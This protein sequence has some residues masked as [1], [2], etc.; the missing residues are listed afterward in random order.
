MRARTTGFSRQRSR[1]QG[2]EMRTANGARHAPVADDVSLQC[3]RG[4]AQDDSSALPLDTRLK[5]TLLE[6]A[7]LKVVLGTSQR[8]VM[9]VQR[10]VMAVREQVE[11]WKV[12]FRPQVYA[13][14]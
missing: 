8:K 10:K 12:R 11:T 4:A 7:E 5:Q 14:K 2:V 13:L 9:A 1:K 3:P 6:L